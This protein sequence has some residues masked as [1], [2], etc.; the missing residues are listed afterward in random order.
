M[1]GEG[2]WNT[3][4]VIDVSPKVP[5]FGETGATA[6]GA[7]KLDN[8]NTEV[9]SDDDRCKVELLGAVCE[10]ALISRGEGK[11]D[12]KLV[13]ERDGPEW[14]N[15]DGG[16]VGERDCAAWGAGDL[17]NDGGGASSKLRSKSTFLGDRGRGNV[18]AVVVLD[19]VGR[20][21]ARACICAKAD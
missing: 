1:V 21:K 8:E 19:R 16:N 20:G 11:G 17:R 6:G 12:A 14:G 15:D 5:F 3:G 7:G 18:V 13:G 9:A 2:G 10:R 4:F